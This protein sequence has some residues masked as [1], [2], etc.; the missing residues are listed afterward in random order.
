MQT[1]LAENAIEEYIIYL[2]T[3]K[4]GNGQMPGRYESTPV[5]VTAGFQVFP[6]GDYTVEIM[7]P[8]AREYTAKD[9]LKAGIGVA[10][11]I[12]DGENKGKV[13]SYFGD[14]LNEFGK[15][16]NKALLLAANGLTTKDEDQKKWNEENKDKDFSF[17]T[18]DKTVGEGWLQLK[19]KAVVVHV[20]INTATDG[21]GKQFQKFNSFRPVGAAQ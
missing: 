21:S 19:G 18:A 17:N 1:E 16:Q 8:K 3:N 11:K 13:M 9:E 15:A 12:A 14:E 10:L 6:E 20:G 7:E 2:I 4:I 5:E